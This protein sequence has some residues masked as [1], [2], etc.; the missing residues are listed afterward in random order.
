M[1]VRNCKNCGKLFQY[2]G[3]PLCPA[4]NKKLEDKFFEAMIM[5]TQT[6]ANTT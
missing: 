2:V 1:D 5:A 4:C 3:K 6:S